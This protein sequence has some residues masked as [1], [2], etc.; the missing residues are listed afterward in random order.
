MDDVFSR[1]A[2]Q[3]KHGLHAAGKALRSQ[4]GFPSLPVITIY[5]SPLPKVSAL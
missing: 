5:K 1:K 3:P 2:V 4:R